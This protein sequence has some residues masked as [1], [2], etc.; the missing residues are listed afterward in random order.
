MLI[1]DV[2]SSG[3]LVPK[4]QVTDYQYRG[5]ELEHYNLLQYFVD[6][7]ET[8]IYKDE[9]ESADEDKEIS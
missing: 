8:D 9:V 5:E 1:L 7:Y 6:T 4:N 2:D 3:H